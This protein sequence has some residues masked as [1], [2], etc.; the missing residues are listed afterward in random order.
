MLIVVYLVSNNTQQGYNIQSDEGFWDCMSDLVCKQ[1]ILL[2]IL[3]GIEGTI[4]LG[5]RGGEF[6]KKVS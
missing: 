5:I 6:K 3:K 4:L 2:F 1:L